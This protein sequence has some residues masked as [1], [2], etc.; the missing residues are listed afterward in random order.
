MTIRRRLADEQGVALVLAVLIIAIITIA[1]SSA[2]FFTTGSQSHG[3]RTKSGFT[4]YSLAQAALSAATEQLTTHYYDSSGQPHDNTTTLTQMASWAAS[5]SQQSPSSSSACTS[6][7]VSMCMTWSTILECPSGTTCS[8]GAP[9]IVVTGVEKAIWHVTGVGVVP[10]PTGSG[11]ISR[12]IT[13]DIP[14][15]APPGKTASVDNIYDSVYAGG[16]GN[17]CDMNMSQGVSFVAPVYVVGNLCINNPQAGVSYPGIL[18]VGGYLYIKN[19][20]VGTAAN[21]VTDLEVKGACNGTQQMTPTCVSTLFK[22]APPPTVNY[23]TDGSNGIYVNPDATSNPS[24]PNQPTEDFAARKTEGSPYSCTGIETLGTNPF[25][26]APANGDYSCTAPSG[27]ITWNHS[28]QTLTIAGNVYI[29]GNL[30]TANTEKA[31]LSGIGGIFVDGTTSFG[32]NTSLCVNGWTGQHDCSGGSSWDTT[33]N[34]LMV[35][36][37]KDITGSNLGLQGGLYSLKNIDFGQGQTDIYGPL[38][39]MSVLV[40]GQ[41]AATTMPTIPTVIT[42]WPNTPQP[43]WTLG[44]PVNGTY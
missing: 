30:T 38:I 19:G 27:S 25:D 9:S 22:P 37:Q 13:I 32:Q 43:Y 16:T 36:G 10:N 2:I 44:A 35:F 1:A 21:P 41:Q 18:H 14:V 34:F 33:K 12:T 5:G 7:P 31:N 17:P 15:N 23:W 29:Y 11:S 24:F 26:L 20:N 42:T 6:S 40:P 3:Y 39:G 4:A 28:T 8:A